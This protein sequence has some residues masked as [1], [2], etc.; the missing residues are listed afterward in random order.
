MTDIPLLVHRAVYQCEGCGLAVLWEVRDEMPEHQLCAIC[1]WCVEFIEPRE[2]IEVR[3]HL[4]PGGWRKEPRH[5]G[6]Q[7]CP[8]LI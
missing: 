5:F 3:R 2:I 7:P 6:R 8:R 1:A 4:E